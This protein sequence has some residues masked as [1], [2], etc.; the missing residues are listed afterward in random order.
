[1][2]CWE[3]YKIFLNKTTNYYKNSQFCH[4]LWLVL[5]LNNSWQQKL[6]LEFSLSACKKFW[7][8]LFNVF[9][10]IGYTLSNV[11]TFNNHALCSRNLSN[12]WEHSL[13]LVIFSVLSY[14][15]SVSGFSKLSLD[16]VLTLKKSKKCRLIWKYNLFLFKILT[17]RQIWSQS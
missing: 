15:L 4:V 14:P 1:M 5:A 10:Y 3:L 9:V 17:K 8:F 6:Q 2:S 13:D 12:Q 11:A 7:I 16:F